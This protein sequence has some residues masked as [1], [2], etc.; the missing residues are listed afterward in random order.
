MTSSCNSPHVFSDARRASSLSRTAALST[1]I[2]R[3]MP[4]RALS[5]SQTV[6]FNITTSSSKVLMRADAILTWMLRASR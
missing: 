4:E 6:P 5:L 1:S 3:P 2:S